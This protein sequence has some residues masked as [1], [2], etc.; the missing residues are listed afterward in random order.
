[1]KYER[2]KKYVWS[3]AVAVTFVLSSGLAGNALVQ[4]QSRDWDRDRWERRERERREEEWRERQRR[5]RQNY[6]YGG[7]GNYGGY[8]RN[9]GDY[10]YSREEQKGYRDGLNRGQE[11]AR[12]RRSPNPNNSSHYRSGNGAYREGFR[13]GYAQGYRQYGGGY[14]RW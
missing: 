4:A 13:R 14:R 12:D 2:L 7:Y 8:G 11:D 5:E 9:G 6:P 1:M 3:L 10:G